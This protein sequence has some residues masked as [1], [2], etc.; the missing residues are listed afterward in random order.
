MKREATKNRI[1]LVG[2]P[3]DGISL[4]RSETERPGDEWRHYTPENSIVAI[5]VFNGEVWRYQRSIR[6]PSPEDADDFFEIFGGTT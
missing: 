6:V 2:G 3:L 1:G 4:P 5:Y